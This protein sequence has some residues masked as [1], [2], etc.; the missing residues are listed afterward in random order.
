MK[1]PSLKAV[2]TV[3]CLLCVVLMLFIASAVAPVVAAAAANTQTSSTVSTTMTHASPPSTISYASTMNAITRESQPGIS[4]LYKYTDRVIRTSLG[5]TLLE[6]FPKFYNRSQVYLGTLQANPPGTLLQKLR[7]W[8]QK[9][10]PSLSEPE[11]TNTLALTEPTLVNVSL[12]SMTPLASSN[13]TMTASASNTSDFNTYLKIY[14]QSLSYFSLMGTNNYVTWAKRMKMVFGAL[15]FMNAVTYLFIGNKLHTSP[16]KERWILYCYM[17]AAVMLGLDAMVAAYAIRGMAIFDILQTQEVNMVIRVLDGSTM[18]P[19]ANLQG[20]IIVQSLD[21]LN[22]N[23]SVTQFTYLLGCDGTNMSQ[24]FYSLQCR[25]K[26]EGQAC[27]LKAPPPPGVWRLRI[28]LPGFRNYTLAQ[29]D[30]IAAGSSF[31]GTVVLHPST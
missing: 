8:M 22:A 5:I 6:E 17:C 2:S 11:A 20:N 25:E 30:P 28:N 18:Q 14:N 19:I 15:Q 21:A 12:F 24:G 16:H 29:T 26:A 10:S 23:E 7:D 31:Y 13:S 1:A 9:F 4:A 3:S 27:Y